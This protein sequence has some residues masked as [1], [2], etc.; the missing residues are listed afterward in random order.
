[1][2]KLHYL[3]FVLI[4]SMTALFLSHQRAE[5]ISGGGSTS[6]SVDFSTYSDGIVVVSSGAGTTYS[7]GT[8]TAGTHVVSAISATG[9]V[10]CSTDTAFTGDTYTAPTGTG[11]MIYTGGTPSVVSSTTATGFLGVQNGT[12]GVYSSFTRTITDYAIDL[13]FNQLTSSSSTGTVIFRTPYALSGIILT[14]VT[15]SEGA[16]PFSVAD[17]TLQKCGGTNLSSCAAMS[18]AATISTTTPFV[19]TMSSTTAAAGEF[20]KLIYG[21]VSGTSSMLSRI[22]ATPSG[23]Q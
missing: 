7:G 6:G 19:H 17:V 22:T 23:V 3:I 20:F 4:L 2:R 12:M 5:S 21:T 13:S 8:C 15:G 11:F 9:L 16:S 18:T 14:S 10:T 1:M